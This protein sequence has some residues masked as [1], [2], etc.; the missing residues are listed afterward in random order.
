MVRFIRNI[1]L[2]VTLMTSFNSLGQSPVFKFSTGDEQ[3]PV[4][5]R[6]YRSVVQ[7][8][9]GNSFYTGSFQ[10]SIDINPGSAVQTVTAV[11]QT[12][13]FVYSLDS[14]GVFRWGFSL[15]GASG[16]FG[17][18]I[19][20]ERSG[21]ILLFGYQSGNIDLDPDTGVA[22]T[23]ST[24]K[25]FLA[26][27]SPSGQ[28]LTGFDLPFISN[29][30]SSI[31]YPDMAIDNND[32]IVVTGFGQG[33]VDPSAGVTSVG[34]SV[35]ADIIVAKYSSLLQLDWAFS[36]NSTNGISEVPHQIVVDSLNNIYIAGYFSNSNT[37][38]FDPGAGTANLTCS[39]SYDIFYAKYNS[40]G[41]YQ[42]AKNL[43]TGVSVYG[44]QPIRMCLMSGG[45][46]LLFGQAFSSIDLDPS[47]SATYV[48]NGQFIALYTQSSG[49]LYLAS[50]VNLG[51]S[52]L[53]T[54]LAVDKIGRIFITGSFVD[55]ADFDMTSS[56]IYKLY[57]NSS[58]YCSEY[59]ASYSS[60]LQFR[61]ARNLTTSTNAISGGW[62]ISCKKPNS[63]LISSRIN[64]SGD[65]NPSSAVYPVSSQFT[66]FCE[67]TCWTDGAIPSF[68]VRP[69]DTDNNGVVDLNDLIPIGVNYNDSSYAR[70]TISISWSDHPVPAWGAP[71]QANGQDR[72]H[73]DCNGDG[74]VNTDDTLAI[75]QNYGLVGLQNPEW[76]DRLQTGPEVHFIPQVNSCHAGDTVRI[77]VMAGSM[78]QPFSTLLGAGWTL[79]LNPSYIQ[80]NSI[81][82]SYANSVLA[83]S[84]SYL[85]LNRILSTGVTNS[86]VKTDHLGISGYGEIG[87]I[88]FI[89]PSN[90]TT[91]TIV[92]LQ[93]VQ[94][95]LIDENG[96]DLAAIP[97][98]D[99][100]FINMTSGIEELNADQWLVY[101]NPIRGNSIHITG[102]LRAE[103]VMLT[104]ISGRKI[105]DLSISN[106]SL[107]VLPEGIEN[108]T[109]LLQLQTSKGKVIKKVVR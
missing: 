81:K 67:Q 69:G 37:V 75:I 53:I 93:G 1:V 41:V 3:L 64:G 91:Q 54:D 5:Y 50:A 27:Y 103:S 56:G 32:N 102:P 7:D 44:T 45:R 17:I 99:T 87:E 13:I 14:M 70:D 23:P 47:A 61:W 8:S 39:A 21:N 11:G 52:N 109:Y 10:G 2:V 18:K 79:P 34:G 76:I 4:D 42:W 57:G 104:D 97:G 30:S 101:P 107:I 85:K 25:V 60:L 38:D 40:S 31:D 24:G 77:H 84:A 36:L 19:L 90:Y 9:L 6:I 35:S 55:S 58:P 26:R 100:L 73:V 51:Y 78:L 80:S 92:P 65:M 63:I 66:N 12:D 108:G 43:T 48:P 106:E 16:D 33:D 82:F 83:S 86:I 62:L 94:I 89:I 88:S 68:T 96:A 49:S 74:A 46:L 15:G 98:T 59:V 105:A 95:K 29:Q 72:A 71:L 28:F 20:P 22:T